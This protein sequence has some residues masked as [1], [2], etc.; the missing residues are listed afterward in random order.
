MDDFTR[1]LAAARS[2]DR[3]ALGEIVETL[4]TYLLWVANDGMASN[5][6]SKVGAS[7]VVQ[8][9]LTAVCRNIEAFRGNSPDELRHWILAILNHQMAN[10]RRHYQETARRATGREVALESVSLASR[11]VVDEH[12][13]IVAIEREMEQ[14]VRSAIDG[15]PEPDRRLIGYRQDDDLSFDEIGRR[16]GITSE[17]A[18]KRFD[19]MKERLRSLLVTINGND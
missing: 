3:Q 13:A 19:R 7:D 4:R 15:L 18:R 1:K 9:T 6:R 10:L 8:E 5:L 16:M 14:A 12:P 11:G 2:G 17:A